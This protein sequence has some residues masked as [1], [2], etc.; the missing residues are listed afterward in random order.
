[1]KNFSLVLVALFVAQSLF[2]QDPVYQTFRDR[3]VINSHS[4]E[5][6]AKR[7][8]DVRIAH[9]FGDFAGNAGGWITFYGLENAADVSIG[10]EYG[11][12]DQLTVGLARSKGAGDLKQLVSGSAKYRI[13]QQRTEGTP[14][15]LAVVGMSSVST[16]DESDN[17][18]SINYFDV[19][20]HRMV[21]HVSLLGARKFSDGFSLQLGAGLTH[22]NV[23]PANGQNNIVHVGLASRIQVTK[24]LGIIA[25]LTVPFID[26]PSER[27]APFGIGFEFDTG[28]HV[29]Q[30]NL[31]NAKGIM[32][33][34]YI[35]YTFSN[36]ED[37]EWRLGFTISRMFNL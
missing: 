8:L 25:D 27:F 17:P 15:T 4:V 3:W 12:T 5:T 22:R 29:F 30:L 24:A 21:H 10:A 1:M 13:A 6:L 20:S 36:W 35:P 16:M 9:R 7:K 14:V 23:V 2:A 31:T 37:G 11:V 19:F 18:S 34:D 33:T 28:G 32:P 26:E